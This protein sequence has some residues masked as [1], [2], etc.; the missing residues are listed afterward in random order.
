MLY[1]YSNIAPTTKLCGFFSNH[2][3]CHSLI[4][5]IDACKAPEAPGVLQYCIYDPYL[6]A[7]AIP[8]V[9]LVY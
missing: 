4:M 1:T 9:L 5:D 2:T 7:N 8:H 3:A 6:E